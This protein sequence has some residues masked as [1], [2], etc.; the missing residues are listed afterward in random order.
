M[1]HYPPSSSPCWD[2]KAMFYG[3]GKRKKEFWKQSFF[4]FS[5]PFATSQSVRHEGKHEC[6]VYWK[7]PFSSLMHG[8]SIFLPQRTSITGCFLGWGEISGSHRRA[9]CVW[10][11]LECSLKIRANS[12]TTG[13]TDAASANV[14]ATIAGGLHNS[15]SLKPS[16]LKHLASFIFPWKHFK[17]F[18]SPCLKAAPGSF[19]ISPFWE[20]IFEPDGK[21]KHQ[22]CRGCSGQAMVK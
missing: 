3:N 5:V 6:M 1:L 15:F 4:F 20:K 2:H 8:G 22:L 19:S 9:I 16:S 13:P 14:P 7:Q 11:L 12:N 18:S 21:G 17:V 10:L